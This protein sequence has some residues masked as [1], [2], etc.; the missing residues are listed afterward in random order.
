MVNTQ[1]LRLLRHCPPKLLK[2]F[3]Q[4]WIAD[5]AMQLLPSSHARQ[6][7]FIE[8]VRTS[9]KAHKMAKT[10]SHVGN[11]GVLRHMVLLPEIGPAVKVL[12]E[13]LA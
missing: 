5:Q 11:V 4:I 12:A 13:G 8:K 3:R 2:P 6:E 7:M 9:S 1:I 10:S